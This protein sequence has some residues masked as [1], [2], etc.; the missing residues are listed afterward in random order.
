[1]AVNYTYILF[2]HFISINCNNDNSSSNDPAFSLYIGYN[3]INLLTAFGMMIV[4][5]IIQLAEGKGQGHPAVASVSGI[6]N[7]FGVCVYSFMCHHSLPSL[8]TPIRNKAGLSTVLAADYTLILVFYA[9]LS[10]TGIFTFTKIEDLYT[11]NFQPNECGRQ[12][13]TTVK[14][15]EYFLALFPVFTLST[16][17]PIIAIT[18]RNNLQAMLSGPTT[19]PLI[20]RLLLPLLAVIPSTIVAII[21][22][23]VDFLV[24][25]TG[26][27]AGVGIQYAI[28]ACLVLLARR[29]IDELLIKGGVQLHRSPFS[30][31]FW[32]Y[33]VLVWAILCVVFVT[34][35]HI[36]N[37]S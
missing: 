28:P 29:H 23:R 4:L 22:N 14:F 30:H 5:T 16:S 17:F 15:I 32:V 37:G 35:N 36:I 34:I 9:L 20:S 3:W 1:M 18:L 7:L 21:T 6:P 26:S 33:L 24:G 19:H 11:L 12:A 27:Y 13:V 25:I 8:I 10:F 31:V 2:M